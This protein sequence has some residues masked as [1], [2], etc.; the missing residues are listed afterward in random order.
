MVVLTCDLCTQ[1]ADL[2]KLGVHGHLH[3]VGMDSCLATAVTK[4][5][6]R[7]TYLREGFFWLIV[8]ETLNHC[9]TYYMIFYQQECGSRRGW[10]KTETMEGPDMPFKVTLLVTHFFHS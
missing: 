7:K 10:G 3:L 5:A 4:I 2:R 1:E 6:K 9:M 8:S